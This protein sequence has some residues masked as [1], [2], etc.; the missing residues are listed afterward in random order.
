MARVDATPPDLDD[1]T[2]RSQLT[3]ATCRRRA[4]H[5]QADAVSEQ[6]PRYRVELEPQWINVLLPRS[7]RGGAEA[8]ASRLREEDDEQAAGDAPSLPPLVAAEQSDERTTS[9]PPLIAAPP[10]LQEATQA[11]RAQADAAVDAPAAA[12]ATQAGAAVDEPRGEVIEQV[13]DD[14]LT[15]PAVR[16]LAPP[17]APAT[18]PP[19]VRGVRE[20]VLAEDIDVVLLDLLNREA[21][22]DN[23]VYALEPP[24]PPDRPRL[25]GIKILTPGDLLEGL[26]LL[27]EELRSQLAYVNRDFGLTPGE[28]ETARATIR[29]II[30]QASDTSEFEGAVERARTLR[31]AAQTGQVP[32][33]QALQDAAVAA[34]EALILHVIA[35]LRLHLATLIHVDDVA[36]ISDAPRAEFLDE[37]RLLLETTQ[38][39]LDAARSEDHRAVLARWT[40]LLPNLD[41]ILRLLAEWS[42]RQRVVVNVLRAAGLTAAAASV[43]EFGAAV[44]GPAGGGLGPGGLSGGGATATAAIVRLSETPASVNAAVIAVSAAATAAG[45]G[46]PTAPSPPSVP[47]ASSG[48]GAGSAGDGPPPPPWQDQRL[49]RWLR[50]LWQARLRAQPDL[51]QNLQII[52][53]RRNYSVIGIFDEMNATDGSEWSYRVR[54][55]RTGV[56]AQIDG[57]TGEGGLDDLL[58]RQRLVEAKS[59]QGFRTRSARDPVPRNYDVLDRLRGTPRTVADVIERRRTAIGEFRQERWSEQMVRQ[60]ELAAD[61]GLVVEW[62]CT[63]PQSLRIAKALVDRLGLRGQVFVVDASGLVAP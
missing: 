19:G 47:P 12:T 34:N 4:G 35:T 43:L 28:R 56:T 7:E 37:W 51:A 44:F 24:P 55:R 16:A 62:R 5:I 3:P 8:P 54:D 26:G 13:L 9:A 63:G 50:A 2:A 49:P 1:P 61:N 57:W 6:T 59:D 18:G 45:G 36:D 25:F 29:N 23:L 41:P 53:E 27:G 32:A 38:P 14:W 31:R 15:T 48:G 39:I 30:R 20:R 58:G 60:A 40:A 21:A 52:A 22:V 46:A 42:E 33:E 10:E 11:S 17:T